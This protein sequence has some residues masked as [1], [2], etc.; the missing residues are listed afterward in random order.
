MGNDT[1]G[2]SVLWKNEDWLAVWIGFLII[3]LVLAGLTIKPP[4]FKW[5][6]DGE[7]AQFAAETSPA[8]EKLAKQAGEK[9]KQVSRRR[10]WQ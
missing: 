2:W 5:T 1:S 8:L 3:I 9:G 7:F 10:Q 6:T 4:K